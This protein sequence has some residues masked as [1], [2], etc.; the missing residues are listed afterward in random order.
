MLAFLLK[1]ELS[2]IS[3]LLVL[4]KFLLGKTNIFEMLKKLC[5]DQAR[6]KLSQ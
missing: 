3:E 5:K 1:E 6:K 2:C 4:K